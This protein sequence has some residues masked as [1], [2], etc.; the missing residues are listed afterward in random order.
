MRLLELP[1]TVDLDPHLLVANLRVA[2]A[3]PGQRRPQSVASEFC[4]SNFSADLRHVDGE[5]RIECRAASFHSIFVGN[6]G[7]DLSIDDQRVEIT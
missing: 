1:G 2:R 4:G 3:Q 6:L 7:G 5:G